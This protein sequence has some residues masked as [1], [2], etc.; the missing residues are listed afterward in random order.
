MQFVLAKY[1]NHI[2]SI[3][4]TIS[5]GVLEFLTMSLLEIAKTRDFKNYN[6]I[7][8]MVGKGYRSDI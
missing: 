7:L 5:G 3:D 8:A 2:I 6:T 4:G 1:S